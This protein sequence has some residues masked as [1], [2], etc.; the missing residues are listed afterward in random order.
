MVKTKKVPPDGGYGWF[1][2]FAYALHHVSRNMN[3]L[4]KLF[5][6]KVCFLIIFC[7]CFGIIL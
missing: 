6:F 3:K 1:I 5:L 2:V 7:N 4:N